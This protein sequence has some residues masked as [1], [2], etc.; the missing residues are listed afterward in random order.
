MKLLAID[1]VTENCSIGLAID[2]EPVLLLE[3]FTPAGHSK[4]I[5]GMIRQLMERAGIRFA[6]LAGIVVDTGPG[7]FTGVRIGIGVA[8]GLAYA[9]NLRCVSVTSLQALAVQC[10]SGLCLSAIDARMKQVYWALYRCG[11]HP[12]ELLCGPFVSDPERI[13]TTLANHVAD[14]SYCDENIY[15]IGSGWDTY[16]PGLPE[17]LHEKTIQVLPGGFPGASQ[18]LEIALKAPKFVPPMALLASYVRDDIV[19]PPDR[20]QEPAGSGQGPARVD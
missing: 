2:D 3:A 12:P 6:D 7:S 13:G 10:S 8:Q 18:L 4:L 19:R 16:R 14:N 15:G 11:N 1:T 20:G 17:T 5:H 9:A